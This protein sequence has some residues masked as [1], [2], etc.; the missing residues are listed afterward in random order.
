MSVKSV[1]G[2]AAMGVDPVG[3]A[4]VLAAMGDAGIPDEEADRVVNIESRWNPSARNSASGAVGLL[5]WMPSTLAKLGGGLIPGVPDVTPAVVTK[6]SRSGQVPLVRATFSTSQGYS[7]TRAGDAYL[8]IA[9]PG[10]FHQPPEKVIYPVG[11]SA[12]RLNP[13]WR[14]PGDGPVTVRRILAIGDGSEAPTAN[15]G[16]KIGTAGGGALGG[17]SGGLLL[18]L[19]VLALASRR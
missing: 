9:A 11:S 7:R 19:V 1:A 14:E 12:W 4:G 2:L 10:F 13:G 15:A 3:V 17:A 6:L 8:W 18:L 16:K 5:Q